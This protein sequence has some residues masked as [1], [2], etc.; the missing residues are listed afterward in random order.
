MNK[1]TCANQCFALSLILKHIHICTITNI[2]T[3][4]D[5]LLM[6]IQLLYVDT[7]TV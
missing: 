1:L 4:P 5:S 2:P 7:K 3:L 6:P